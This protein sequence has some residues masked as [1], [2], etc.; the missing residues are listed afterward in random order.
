MKYGVDG[1]VTKYPLPY[2]P[3]VIIDRQK[4]LV[5]I[6]SETLEISSELVRISSDLVEISSETF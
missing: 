4:H 1:M 5:K 6:Y 3:T 2:L